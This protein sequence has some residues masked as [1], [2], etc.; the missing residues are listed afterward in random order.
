[1]KLLLVWQLVAALSG[2]SATAKVED[3]HANSIVI[4]TDEHFKEGI[5]LG[6]QVFDQ[7]T[8]TFY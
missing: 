7:A 2:A 1:M 3:K 6:D 4:C 5:Y 8:D